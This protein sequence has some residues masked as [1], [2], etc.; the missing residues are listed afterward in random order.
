MPG[1]G[2][3][4]Q[5][6]VLQGGKVASKM[7]DRPVAAIL[8]DVQIKKAGTPDRTNPTCRANRT[9]HF[10]QE[11]ATNKLAVIV[12]PSIMSVKV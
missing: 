2:R 8:T 1:T 12:I 7:R 11:R 5:Q 4:L 6:V 3:N 9:L 10:G